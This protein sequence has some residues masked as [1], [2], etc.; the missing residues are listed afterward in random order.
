LEALHLAILIHQ[1]LTKGEDNFSFAAETMGRA[2]MNLGVADAANDP[3]MVTVLRAVAAYLLREW[4]TGQ[5]VCA[6]IEEEDA[7]KSGVLQ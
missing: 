3:S 7:A 5:A 1:L 2:A 6:L 4:A